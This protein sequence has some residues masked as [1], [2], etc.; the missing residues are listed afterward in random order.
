MTKSYTVDSEHGGTTVEPDVPC[1]TC[2]APSVLE[3]V[4]VSMS[5]DS[6]FPPYRA[7]PGVRYCSVSTCASNRGSAT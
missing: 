1:P 7:I 6:P 4:A 2:G 5:S 3:L